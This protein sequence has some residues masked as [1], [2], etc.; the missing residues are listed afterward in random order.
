M[1]GSE[2][3]DYMLKIGGQKRSSPFITSGGAG[4][5]FCCLTNSQVLGWMVSTKKGSLEELEKLAASSACGKLLAWLHNLNL[6]TYRLCELQ[7]WRYH[8]RQSLA[9][10]SYQAAPALPLWLFCESN[11]NELAWRSPGDSLRFARS[12]SNIPS[13]PVWI[14]NIVKILR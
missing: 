14:R 11:C 6:V 13:K 3:S 1:N 9:G 7:A 4:G 8:H 5:F 10:C 12:S 2:V